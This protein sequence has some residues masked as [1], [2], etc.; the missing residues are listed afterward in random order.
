[1]IELKKE[2][3]KFTKIHNKMASITNTYQKKL[4]DVPK[5]Y[6]K[7]PDLLYNM[8]KIYTLKINSIMKNK[9]KPFFARIDFFADD[10]K[11][12]DI[13]YI[14]KVGI[15]DS[16]GKLVTVDWRSP[17]A[18]LYYD[19]VIGQTKYDSPSGII[20]GELTLKRQFNIEDG[21]ILSYTDMDT[22]SNDEILLPYL[23]DNADNRLKNIVST[24]Q[25]EQN[26]IIR[27]NIGKN[28]IIQG[29]AGSGKTTVA[30]HRIAYLVYTYID[31]IKPSQYLIIGTNK[32]F[33]NYISGVLPDLDVND[34][35]QMTFEEI[36]LQSIKEKIKVI[37]YE[38]D[39]NF[40]GFKTSLNIKKRIDVFIDNYMKSLIP[41]SDFIIDNYIIL[42]SCKVTEIYKMI[43]EKDN[44][45]KIRKF[46]IE[47]NRYIINNIEYIYFNILKEY[48]NKRINLSPDEDIKERKIIEKI[49][50][51][52]CKNNNSYL[53]SYLR[54]CFPKTT[55][56]YKAF[57]KESIKDFDTSKTLKN[58]NKNM[59]LKEDL[60]ALC[61]IKMNFETINNFDNIKHV[62]VDEAQDYNDFSFFVLKKIFKNATFSIFGD[63]SQSI[64]QY[65]SIS[66]WDQVIDNMNNS[67]TEIKYLLKSYRTTIEIMTEANKVTE[68]LNLKNAEPVIRHG[69][70]VQYISIDHNKN[71]EI[72]K[73]IDNLINKKYKTIAII[74]KTVNE[75]EHLY[76]LV[77]TDY[78]KIN[79]IIS[80]D[81]NYNGGICILTSA[82][83][84]GLE[85]DAVII[86]DAS[87]T[88]FEKNI[89]DMKLLYV[90]M[91]RALH[92][93]YVFYDNEMVIN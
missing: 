6:K 54:N 15:M 9:D 72:C 59:I 18:S 81:M 48:N 1:M 61:Y 39:K 12:K 29:V 37:N 73:I 44:A 34:V 36:L 77:S 62:V 19:G 3:E 38:E 32:F 74:C 89:V 51:E 13:C 64:F 26:A 60:F 43:N 90:S 11:E 65:K 7:N 45:S 17:I 2:Q 92:E 56:L 69:K 68:L 58:L 67:N 16:D 78:P 84:K 41:E 31:K 25:H 83:S 40:L 66:S 14:S 28:I 10:K 82:L 93:L 70:E 53:K 76:D 42:K 35:F 22:V 80:E 4:E 86:N 85:F 88:N 23:A 5:T 24:I 52:I 21:K 8:S 33:I 63:L 50:K 71:K 57:I 91:T 49:K 79:K 20:D 30:L 55:T 47:V 75:V 27:E 46:Y 87:I